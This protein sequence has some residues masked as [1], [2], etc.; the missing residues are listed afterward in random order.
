MLDNNVEIIPSEP[1]MMKKISSFHGLQC[2]LARKKTHFKNK[3]LNFSF[4]FYFSMQLREKGS[5][6]YEI[7]RKRGLCGRNI[8]THGQCRRKKNPI[9]MMLALFSKMV[10]Y[11]ANCYTRDFL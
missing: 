1:K 8:V 5:G 6:F 11:A 4:F 7:R 3:G 10:N 9:N 2:S